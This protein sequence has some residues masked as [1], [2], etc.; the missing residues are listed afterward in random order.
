[1][2][3]RLVTLPIEETVQKS[4]GLLCCNLKLVLGSLES[5]DS[6]I[7]VIPY[8]ISSLWISYFLGGSILCISTYSFLFS[9]SIISFCFCCCFMGY[10]Y[11]IFNVLFCFSFLYFDFCVVFGTFY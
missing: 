2:A 6:I 1:M 11:F 4:S 10:V 9:K 8:S 7:I 5:W 3:G